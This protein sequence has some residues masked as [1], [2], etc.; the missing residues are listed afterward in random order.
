MTDLVKDPV[1]GMQIRPDD[2]AATDVHEGRTFYFCNTACHD[3]FVRDPHRHGHPADD[4][5]GHGAHT[6]HAGH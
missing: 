6:T 4:D 1:C 5:A 2:A 3:A